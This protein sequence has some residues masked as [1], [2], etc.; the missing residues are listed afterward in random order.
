MMYLLEVAEGGNP[1]FS[2]LTAA[3]FEP[4]LDGVKTV[5]PLLIPIV[6]TIAG[7]GL[8]VKMIRK[9]LK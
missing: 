8:A 4:V 6:V 9:H 5:M 1:M 3:S 2:G 7:I